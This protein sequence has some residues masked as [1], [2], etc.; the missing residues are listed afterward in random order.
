MSKT[1]KVLSL[2]LTYPDEE[3]KRHAGELR[4]ALREEALLPKPQQALIEKLIRELED[5]DLYELQE[6][7]VLLF[8]RTRSLSLHLFEHIHGEG[9]DRGE[10]MLDL[11]AH[12][13]KQGYEIASAEL[14]DFLPLFLEFLSTLPFEEAC[15]LLSQ[16]LH[17]IAA[18][19]QRLQRR[20]SVYAP[21]FQVLE[22]IATGKPSANR[23]KELLGM[24]DDDP[25]DF[26]QLDEA[27]EDRP[28]TFGPGDAAADGCN[29]N[30]I[31]ARL[32]AAKRPARDAG[33]PRGT[34]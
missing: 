34:R 21:V 15:E 6:R 23:L 17:I 32:R 13:E 14:P 8:D 24:S 4:D 5:R 28:V 7:Y 10:A 3:I 12:Y 18:L 2:L 19:R 31:A 1:F 27:W 22:T 16:P 26:A 9:R 25:D 11:K 33:L 20:G 29:P 30:R